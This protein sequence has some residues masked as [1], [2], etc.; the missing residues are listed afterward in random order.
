MRPS[1]AVIGE[2][3]NER[4]HTVTTPNTLS[5]RAQRSAVHTHEQRTSQAQEFHDQEPCICVVCRQAF[6]VSLYSEHVSMWIGMQ[7]PVRMP[8]H[9]RNYV[10]SSVQ[11]KNAVACFVCLSLYVD[12]VYAVRVCCTRVIRNQSPQRCVDRRMYSGGVVKRWSAAMRPTQISRASSSNA[13]CMRCVCCNNVSKSLLWLC[14]YRWLITY[15]AVDRWLAD[16]GWLNTEHET[17]D[18][19]CSCTHI[20]ISW[21]HIFLLSS[22]HFLFSFCKQTNWKYKMPHS[23]RSRSHIHIVHR[24]AAKWAKGQSVRRQ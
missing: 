17:N 18:R 20:P 13:W 12:V 15:Y 9:Q 4:T 22:S 2:G 10:N 24:S 16:W 23:L 6:D 11:N 3:V 21:L 7:E 19:D 14:L 1:V 5:E 8:C